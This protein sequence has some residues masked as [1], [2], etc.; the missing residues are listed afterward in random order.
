MKI[1][2]G[3]NI[4]GDDIQSRLEEQIAD[5]IIKHHKHIFVKANDG[6]CDKVCVICGIR[7]KQ[8]VLKNK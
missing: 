3:F 2:I 1:T 8:A 5:G 7:A 4:T 6:T